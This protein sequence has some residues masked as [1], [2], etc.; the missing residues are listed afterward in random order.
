MLQL[1]SCAIK[2]FLIQLFLHFS[3]AVQ[4][5]ITKNKNGKKIGSRGV[6]CFVNYGC[7][8][9]PPNC[10]EKPILFDRSQSALQKVKNQFIFEV[11]LTITTTYLSYLL[12]LTTAYDFLHINGMGRYGYVIISTY[13]YIQYGKKSFQKRQFSSHYTL[14]MLYLNCR[15]QYMY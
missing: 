3:F 15:I 8:S 9:K 4:T 14:S 7:L 2:A 5:R 6:S 12:E 13:K 11:F 10:S 1:Y